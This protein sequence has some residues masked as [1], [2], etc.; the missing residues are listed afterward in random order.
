MSTPCRVSIGADGKVTQPPIFGGAKTI[1]D[2]VNHIPG[3]V[4]VS[5]P[6]ITHTSTPFADHGLGNATLAKPTPE[7]I[8]DIIEWKLACMVV[9]AEKSYA[10]LLQFDAVNKKQGYA[11]S[12]LGAIILDLKTTMKILKEEKP[13]A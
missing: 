2:I 12:K 8:H 7:T 3:T 1:G 13:K 4:F 9:D 6:I 11:L 10:E 5:K